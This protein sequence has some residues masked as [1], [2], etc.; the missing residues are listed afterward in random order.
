MVARSTPTREPLMFLLKPS[1]SKHRAYHVIGLV[2]V[3][4]LMISL[5]ALG[6]IAWF[7]AYPPFSEWLYWRG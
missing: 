4:P 6:Y 7:Y 1:H 2:L 5:M 3:V